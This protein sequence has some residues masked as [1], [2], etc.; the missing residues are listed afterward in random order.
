VSAPLHSPDWYR[1]APLKLRLR[2]GVGVSR[3]VLRGEVW[4]V[5]T[6]PIS[7]RHHRF[8][9][10]A[11]RFVSRCDGHRSLD[12]IWTEC[13]AEGGD[14]APTQAE[15]IG[16]VAQAH[17]ANLLIGNVAPDAAA[18]VKS[19]ARRRR[20]RRNQQVNPLA[21]RVRLWNP[22]AF[23]DRTTPYV[24]WLADDRMRLALWLV[25]LGGLV[26]AGL[27]ASALAHEVRTQLTTPRLLLIM[28][29]VFPLL[30]A[31]HELAHA[32]TVKA[33]G[34]DV[35]EVGIV[36]ML[37]TP[38]PYVDASAAT[39]FADKRQR[40]AV[41]AAGILVEAI[42][43]TVALAAWTMLEPGLLRDLCLA[44]VVVGG[45]STLLVN[46]NPLMRFDGYHVLCEH[47]DLPNLAQRSSRWWI[48][49]LRRH[50]LRMPQSR[51]EGMLPGEKR[52]LVAFA[53]LA[54]AWRLLLLATL[55]VAFAESSVVLGLSLL[56]AA[57]WVS[58]VWPAWK[59]MRW[60]WKSPEAG[61]RRMQL[62]ATLASSV[63]AALL[64][65]VAIPLPQRTYAP[66]VVWLPDE[67]ILRL[68]S[69]ARVEELLVEDGRRVAAGTPI[70]RL[71]NEELVADLARV[72]AQLAAAAVER[73]RHF[74][75]D[76]GR[77][78]GAEDELQRLKAQASRL[79]DQVDH[80]VLRAGVDGVVVIA[81][82]QRQIGRWLA[83]GQTLAHVLPG[84]APLVR[85]LVRNEDIGL[86]RDRPGA[87]E[88]ALAHAAG[89]TLPAVI[90]RAVPLA[91][92][93]LPSA[94]LGDSA[95]GP[96]AIDRTDASGRTATEARFVFDLRLPAGADAHV[97][98]RA[99]V[100]FTHGEVNAVDW[101]TRAWRHAFLRHF[102]K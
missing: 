78:A 81:D 52:W 4:H 37:L 1:V 77:S 73:Q 19:Q 66:A 35:V 92:L 83:Q 101:L 29:L 84:G 87:I 10:G 11:Y 20:Q 2:G 79:Q 28:W 55:A 26:H 18:L 54:W 44:V 68:R 25:V 12:E 6:D 49:A 13:L 74:E 41:A 17:S 85:A 38:V 72:Q 51:L 63:L 42:A 7:G 5:L 47:R 75:L 67:A 48:M 100:T 98:A 45:L 8:N 61:G 91:T 53:P 76:A 23:L 60:V 36:L 31:V 80:L 3:Q 32:F 96:I 88:V 27:H 43:A 22:D 30:K 58:F 99:L 33:H 94:A 93:Q 82:A 95:G 9:D 16:I 70:A 57:A 65:A 39:A 50:A 90:G 34:G 56:A 14:A 102:D 21:F 86:V 71:S 62:G 24:R 15:A 69:E 46:G 64:L 59:S 97:G 40:V 89:A